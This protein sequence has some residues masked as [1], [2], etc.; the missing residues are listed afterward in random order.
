M[1]IKLSVIILAGNEEKIIAKCLETCSFADEIIL[2]AANSHDQTKKIALKS[3]KQIKI[4]EVNDEYNK[5]FSKWRNLG[6]KASN[7]QW[8]LYIDADE[9]ITPDL[10]KEIVEVINNKEISHYA[11]P[12]AN[13]F[14]GKRVKH[15]GTYP[16]YVKRLFNRKYFKGYRGILHEEPQIQGQLGYLKNDLLHFTHRDL[17][18]MIQKTIAWTDM[19]AK[20]LFESNH[21]KIVSWRIFRM[22]FTKLWQRLIKEK[23]WQDGTIGFISSIYEAFDT[24]IIYARLWELQQNDKKSGNL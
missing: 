3:Y 7:G 10:Q 21:P 2:V 20:A 12:R 15:G 24:F 9:R 1:E 18:S 17:Y 19:E 23:M 6:Y 22:F 11:I 4:I 5:H 14:L 16:D 8:I 13:Y